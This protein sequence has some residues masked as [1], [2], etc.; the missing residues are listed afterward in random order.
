M[1]NE[2]SSVDVAVSGICCNEQRSAAKHP[3]RFTSVGPMRISHVVMTCHDHIA[4]R[5]VEMWWNNKLRELNVLVSW[6]S[7][8]TE[9]ATV[10][11][12]VTCLGGY[13]LFHGM[14]AWSPCGSHFC[15]TPKKL[16]HLQR[17]HILLFSSNTK[18]AW[19]RPSDRCFWCR[20]CRCRL[21]CRWTGEIC[22]VWSRLVVLSAPAYDVHRKTLQP[23]T[24]SISSSQSQQM[25]RGRQGSCHLSHDHLPPCQL[26]CQPPCQLPLQTQNWGENRD[27]NGCFMF[28]GTSHR[29]GYLS[30]LP[31]RPLSCQSLPGRT[32]PS[33]A[34]LSKK[35]SP[36][37]WSKGLLGFINMLGTP[38]VSVLQWSR[39]WIS[40]WF[41]APTSAHSPH[42]V[43]L[44]SPFAKGKM[45]TDGDQKSLMGVLF[46]PVGRPSWK[47]WMTTRTQDDDDVDECE[48]EKQSAQGRVWYHLQATNIKNQMAT[49]TD[50][51]NI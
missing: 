21:I 24:A 25:S 3:R 40:E 48:A 33:R 47:I 29:I 36:G 1:D 20:V 45:R 8:F 23:D 6:S 43:E 27:E 31:I 14:R 11:F 37:E 12:W 28:V 5:C 22:R 44:G 38:L 18:S 49:Q 46:C 30:H 9:E 50:I 2:A 16:R 26:P 15:K 35:R 51:C 34:D 19:W 13:S 4:Q 32:F 7:Y 41:W 42:S 17:H 39:R 10:T